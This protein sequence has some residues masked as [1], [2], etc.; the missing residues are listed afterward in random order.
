[1]SEKNQFYVDAPVESVFEAF[2]DPSFASEGTP[3]IPREVTLTEEGV[4]SF[5]VWGLKVGAVRVPIEMLNVYAEFVPNKRITEKSSNSLVGTWEYIFE[6]AG[7]RTRIT[8]LHHPRGIWSAPAVR[9][10]LDIFTRKMTEKVFLPRLEDAIKAMPEPHQHPRS[11][12]KR[13][14][15]ASR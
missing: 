8:M 2:R 7:D 3:W 15:A 12:H 9:T 10:V 14:V 4:G 1:M 13:A 6:P 11:S 5:V